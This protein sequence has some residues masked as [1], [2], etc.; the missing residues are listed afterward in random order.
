MNARPVLVAAAPSSPT[1]NRH[2]AVQA[3]QRVR[4]DFVP[5][6]L[7]RHTSKTIVMSGSVGP[8]QVVAKVL[9]DRG[10]FWRDKFDREVGMYRAFTRHAPPV[11]V[12][13]LVDADAP[14]GV[15]VL[16]RLTGR[17]LA[18]DRYPAGP[19]PA[20]DITAVLDA[21]ASL[22]RWEPPMPLSGWDYRERVER[23]YRAGLL[24]DDDHRALAVLLAQAGSRRCFAHGDLL[25]SNVRL[26][27]DSGEPGQVALLDWEF[28]GLYLPGFDL[29][30]L[31]VLLG[32]VSPARHL[33]D[34]RI[35]AADPQT[36][37]AFT[38]NQALV[39]TRELRIHHEA[40]PGRW[41]ERRLSTL[42]RDWTAFRAQTLHPAGRHNARRPLARRGRERARQRREDHPGQ[43]PRPPIRRPRSRPA[44]RL[45][46]PVGGSETSG[47]GRMV[48][49]LGPDR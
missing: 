20:D 26:L 24:D 11:R 48:V 28:A 23:D 14:A 13:R 3:V 49:P 8:Q 32:A 37:A 18:D 30:L 15:L 36:R 38:V 25:P 31:W 1:Q 2:H 40:S 6:D 12:P 22:A 44:G 39:F 45:R 42:T 47:P 16:E 46:R 4:P 9:V 10:P 34:T 5:T 17:R 43:A 35:A 21:V 27:A 41:R 19:V 7:L 33:I 29:A